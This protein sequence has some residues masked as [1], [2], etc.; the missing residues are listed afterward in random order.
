M[1]VNPPLKKNF[2]FEKIIFLST[3]HTPLYYSA[4]FIET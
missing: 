4:E 1:K 2:K 3:K